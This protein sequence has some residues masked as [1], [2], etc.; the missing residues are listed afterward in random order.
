MPTTVP[1]S[2]ALAATLAAIDADREAAF[3]LLHDHN[4]RYP[5]GSAIGPDYGRSL[6]AVSAAFASVEASVLAAKAEYFG[7]ARYKNYRLVVTLGTASLVS[8]TGRNGRLLWT[9]GG[10]A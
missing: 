5:L 9:R 10:V 8:P 2:P 3:A 1:A 4:V 7:A 6:D